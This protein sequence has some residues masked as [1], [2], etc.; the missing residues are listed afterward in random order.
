MSD[1]SFHRAQD[2]YAR[3]RRVAYAIV[4]DNA[5]AAGHT[6]A[7]LRLAECDPYTLSVWRASWEGPHP[8]GWGGWDWEPLL[9]H[10]WR[11]PAAFHLAIWSDKALCGLAVGR[12]S[13]R[14]RSG[15][16][17][18]VFVDYIESAHD[19]NHPLRGK[20]AVLAIG[21]ADAYGRALGAHWLR[22]MEPLPSILHLY[23]GMG[24]GIVRDKD[25]VL[26]CERRI[27]P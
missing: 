11:H 26:Y 17:L 3:I 2:R 14:D 12:V 7:P 5:V 8:S 6:H 18:A 10:A 20:I 21:A 1:N 4:R 22:L 25:R 23:V 16:R 27:E 9:R 13:N 15:F 24:F 19:A